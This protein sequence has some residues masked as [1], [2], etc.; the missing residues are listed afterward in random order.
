MVLFSLKASLQMIISLPLLLRISFF[1]SNL[2]KIFLPS[3][4]LLTV[5]H[6]V[7]QSKKLSVLQAAA[8]PVALFPKRI[9]LRCGL[10][11]LIC[12]QEHKKSRQTATCIPTAICGIE[13]SKQWLKVVKW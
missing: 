3:L 4:M 11:M 10:C 12:P 13:N 6:T 7:Q 9:F 8:Q 1:L 5:K 2:Q